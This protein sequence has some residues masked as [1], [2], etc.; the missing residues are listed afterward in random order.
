MKLNVRPA[1]PE[2]AESISKL[3]K[4]FMEYL[5]SLGD[6]GE[7]WITPELYLNEG[8]G[9][10]PAF[11]G[12]VT[13]NKGKIV[14]YL[15]YHQGF[16]AD[17]LIRTLHIIDLYVQEKSR[18]YG[19]GRK[20]MENAAGICRRMGGKQL[21]WSVYTKNKPALA[22]YK[23]LGARFTKDLLFMRLDL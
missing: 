7:A 14:G 8:F 23:S 6:T 10:N 21:F 17:Y 20:L 15:L 1:T 19:A 18:R 16:D 22:F 3:S 12:L 5:R 11:A 4:E 2:D 9:P 13:E